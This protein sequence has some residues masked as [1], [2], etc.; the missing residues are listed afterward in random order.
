MGIVNLIELFETI[1]SPNEGDNFQF[2]AE[3]IPKYDNHRIAK[4]KLGR[5]VLLLSSKN[6][7]EGSLSV[8][9]RLQ[10]ISVLFDFKCNIEQKG[11]LI[12][13]YF[14]ALLFIGKD[15][16]LE[17]Y[18]LGLCGSLVVDLG[19]FP[20]SY[21]VRS[22]ILRLVE[23]FRLR[24]E[25][26]IKTVQGI[27]GELF[28]ISECIDPPKLIKYWHTMPAERFD[29]SNGD[30][31]LE[32]KSSSNGRRIH[33]FSIEQL[34]IPTDSIAII[35]SIF[36]KRA[37]TGKSISDLI[38]KIEN[39]LNGDQENL[40]KIWDQVAAGLG[41]SIEDSI[42]I[43]FDYHLAN[44]SLK[45]YRAEDIP[46]ISLDGVSPLVFDIKF[47]SDIN[48]IDSITKEE[49]NGLGHLFSFL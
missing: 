27:W 23:L 8:N 47:K 34:N 44:E 30:E 22:E 36:V 18:F 41:N 28:L 49:L 39:K 7:V 24:S 2:S 31:R 6:L 33:N 45:F 11:C 19:N 32:V 29:F 43:N 9:L 35:A 40:K 12:E 4:D 10:N 17:K 37:S 5:P 25:P 1:I 42:I 20:N 46:K 16:V 48:N 21:N 15:T 14:T 26:Q 13:K 3:P 38:I